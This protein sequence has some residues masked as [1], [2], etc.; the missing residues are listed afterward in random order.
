MN[1]RLPSPHAVVLLLAAIVLSGCTATKQPV[2]EQSYNDPYS[3]EAYLENRAKKAERSAMTQEERFAY[4]NRTASL[5]Q[6]RNEGVPLS[7]LHLI[8]Q[9]KQVIGTPYVPGGTSP[10]GFD[11]SGFVQWAYGNVGV[12]LPR[13]ARE[14]SATGRAIR[15]ES[16]K[17]GDIVA[18]NHPR[19]GYH[20][21]IY[22]GNGMFIHSP[23]RGKSV[24]I[25]PLSDP[26]FKSTFI[27][28]RRIHSAE[29]DSQAIQ[30]L[31]AMDSRIRRDV[32]SVTRRRSATR[33]QTA[34]EHRVN[35]RRSEARRPAPARQEQRKNKETLVASASPKTSQD[36]KSAPGKVKEQSKKGTP[37]KQAPTGREKK[38]D[39]RT[40]DKKQDQ[41]K[42]QPKNKDK[43]SP[44]PATSPRQ[45]RPEVSQKKEMKQEQKAKEQERK[46][47]KDRQTA[48][49]PRK[50][51]APDKNRPVQTKPANAQPGKASPQGTQATPRKKAPATPNKEKTAAQKKEKA[52]QKAGQQQE[53]KAPQK[54]ASGPSHP[55]KKQEN[56]PSPSRQPAKNG[57]PPPK[58]R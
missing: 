19:R 30:N 6:M 37:E 51:L 8:E 12:H 42:E 25:A 56:K 14:Q 38:S 43:K 35:T 58:A 40:S 15:S 41:V 9:A 52:P 1:M 27:G 49:P 53:K 22:L 44:Q 2:F 50:D 48:Q 10:D 3:F 20:T 57:T 54:I 29:S 55:K 47:Q 45:G 46:N 13:T 4:D 36:S 39:A 32:P 7:N 26:Y 16:M 23:G 17:A 33:K 11:C 18:F 24:S 21:G 31:M 5:A 28:A 34:A